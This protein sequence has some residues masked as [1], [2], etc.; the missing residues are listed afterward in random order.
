MGCATGVKQQLQ[1]QRQANTAR[2]NGAGRRQRPTGAVAANRQATGIKTQP[3]ALPGDP[4]HGVPGVVMCHWKPE[5]GCQT[6][7]HRE[8]GTVRQVAQGAAQH[9]MGGDAADGEAAAMKINE[10]WQSFSSWRIKPNR[11]FMTITRLKGKTLDPMYFGRG[12][13]QHA[14]PHLIGS[15]GLHRCQCVQGHLGRTRHPVE[16]AVHDGG[17]QGAWVTVMT[18]LSGACC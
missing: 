1:A 12:K 7:S 6:I 11:H 14:S 2:L 9:I 4:L 13:I 5:L 3:R 16:H 18:H 8:H 15:A 17:Q 10:H